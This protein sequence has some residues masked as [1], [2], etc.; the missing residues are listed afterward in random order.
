MPL[1]RCHRDCI[2]SD[3][4]SRPSGRR[5][6]LSTDRTWPVVGAHNSKSSP[7]LSAA[8]SVFKDLYGNLWDLLELR[9]PASVG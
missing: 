7:D 4:E 1:I 8:V 6:S 5:S 2:G 3:V 9:A